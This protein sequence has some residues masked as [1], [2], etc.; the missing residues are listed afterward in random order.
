M[1]ARDR[2]WLA[3]ARSS[4]CRGPPADGRGSY[5]ASRG[6]V[7]PGPLEAVLLTA[8]AGGP[9][10]G[11]TGGLVLAF[12]QDC[13]QQDVSQDIVP[14]P[15][16]ADPDIGLG[17]L[18]DLG[19][20]ADPA[21]PRQ[22]FAMGRSAPASTSLSRWEAASL[23]EMQALAWAALIILLPVALLGF[24]MFARWIGVYRGTG[25]TSPPAA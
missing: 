17:R 15:R 1:P 8:A 19:G 21:D 24:T 5:A 14:A 20:P 2:T 13:F 23:R 11:V 12:G 4:C 9:Q 10:R 25:T 16:D 22:R 18:I 3:R 6:R 7:F